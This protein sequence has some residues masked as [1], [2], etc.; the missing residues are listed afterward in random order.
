MFRSGE[1]RAIINVRSFY[2]VYDP[3]AFNVSACRFPMPTSVTTRNE[4]SGQV[5]QCSPASSQDGLT[6][7]SELLSVQNL[8][9]EASLAILKTIR[10]LL[11]VCI[12][13]RRGETIGI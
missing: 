13:V 9:V 4:Q 1:R 7:S 11:Y 12:R 10:I 8:C 3:G 2:D 6:T 5:S